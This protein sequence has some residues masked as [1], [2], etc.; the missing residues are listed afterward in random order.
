[1]LTADWS[2]ISATIPIHTVLSGGTGGA[3]NGGDEQEQNPQSD[4][5][6]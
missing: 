5:I 6:L 2:A 1:M 4:H 3:T